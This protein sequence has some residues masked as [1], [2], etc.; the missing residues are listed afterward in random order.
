MNILITVIQRA[1]TTVNVEMFMMYIFSRFS[2]IF[3][4]MYI[5]QITSIMQ[6]TSN[7]T[8]EYI[9][10]CEIDN[11]AKRRGVTITF[12]YQ[13]PWRRVSSVVEQVGEMK[14]N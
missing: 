12:S 9:N 5:L 6:Y 14:A 1:D 10:L 7:T 8:H 11:F 13:G 4:N 2:N 3:E